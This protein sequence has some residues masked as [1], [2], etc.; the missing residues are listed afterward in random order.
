M[1]IAE[2]KVAKTTCETMRLVPIP[3]GIVGATVS[4]E[5][6]DSAWDDLQKTV[7]F[8]SGVIKD[9][10][11]VGSEVV[12]PAEVVSRAGV[13]LYMGV[14][15]VDTANNV[16][17]PTIWTEL[18]L[19]NG[20][21]APS[22]DSS[23]DPSLPVWAQIQAMIGDLDNLDT[24]AKSNLVAAVNEA[25]TRSGGEVDPA[26]VQKI[27]E[28][29]LK[30]NPPAAGKDG[31]T[32]TIGSNGNWYIGDTDTGKPSRGEDGEVPDIQI[33]TVTTL[34]AGSDATAS[35][36]GTAENPLLN[37]GIPKGADGRSGG[38]GGTDI[39]LG[40]TSATVG[41]TVRIKAVDADG[42]PTAWEAAD[43]P[44]GAGETW[45]FITEITLDDAVNVVTINKDA[46]G[47]S[48]ALK[49]VM[50]DC[51]ITLNTDDPFTNIK[52][53]LNGHV[54]SDNATPVMN[55]SNVRYYSFYAEIIPGSGA[56]CWQACSGAN[57]NW[58]GDLL[59]MGYKYNNLWQS[60]AI[61]SLSIHP[62][63]GNKNIGL[64]GTKIHVLGVRA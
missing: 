62:N 15:G 2:V 51:V 13:N 4:I 44:A 27:V 3:K 7:I 43:L 57:Y 45:Q 6:T 46:N 61:T 59:K 38:S 29:Y 22:G 53:R 16:V 14:Y 35:M 26:T 18:G 63:D 41:Q 25:L 48:F 1:K 11:D 64:A 5:Y 49:R 10:L 20:A 60:D 28:D 8:R 34:P 9:V 54:C 31:I 23:T 42:K 56:L 58:G 55:N 21:A 12:I 19:V 50:I 37:L 24:A 47:N 39:S 32:P 30:A 52:T 40:L 33:G 36:G 17:I